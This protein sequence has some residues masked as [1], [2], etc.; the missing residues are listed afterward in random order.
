MTRV[1]RWTFAAGVALAAGGAAAAPTP[2]PDPGAAASASTPA[3]T[4]EPDAEQ[5]HIVSDGPVAVRASVSPDPSNIGDLLTLEIVAAYP[6][7]YAVNLPTTVQIEPLHLVDVEE[8]EPESTGQGLRKTFRIR[9][10]S[11]TVG[12][13]RT[14][15]FPVTYVDD[16]GA[17]HTIAL[18]AV[19]FVVESLLANVDDVARKG[20]DPPVSIEYPNDLAEIIAWSV[21]G[22]L[23]LA[24]LSWVL[25]RRW[26]A[27][28]KIVPAPPPIPPHE[29]AYAALEEL[30]GG[31][32]LQSEQYADYYVQLTEITKAYLQGRFGVD[33]LDRTTEEIRRELVRAPSVVAPLGAD[34]VIALLQRYDLVKFARFAPPRDEAESDLDGVRDI[35][36]RS[37]PD[38]AAKPESAPERANTEARP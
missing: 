32:L 25:L 37:R 14:R 13:Q 23:L 30:A 36:D 21:A 31:D 3:P 19:P 15:S 29:V 16:G 12:E 5:G 11:F 24:L 10:Q 8:T 33:A 18:P 22:T 2:A 4:A 20:E 28:D 34:D 7:G 6:R 17:V 35:V 26:L 38:R 27:R 1:L 9:M